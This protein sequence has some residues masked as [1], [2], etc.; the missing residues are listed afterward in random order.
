MAGNC[1]SY[2]RARAVDVTVFGRVGD[3]FVD[4]TGGIPPL[5]Q[6]RLGGTAA[7]VSVRQV[8]S[9][10]PTSAS[11]RT[12]EAFAASDSSGVM[13]ARRVGLSGGR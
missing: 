5:V 4:F 6:G 12:N 10:A 13:G 9:F 1:N 8:V 3:T 2:S 7:N 11:G